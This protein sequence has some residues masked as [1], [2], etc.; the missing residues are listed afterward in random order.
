VLRELRAGRLDAS[1][2]ELAVVRDEEPER[3]L[4]ERLGGAPLREEDRRFGA[5]EE[6]TS[7]VLPRRLAG[8]RSGGAARRC[9]VSQ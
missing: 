6:A 7:A 9:G 2:S 3:E 4:E 1:P 8:R 5:S